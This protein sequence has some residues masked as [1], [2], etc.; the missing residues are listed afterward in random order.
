M[1]E[2]GRLVDLVDVVLRKQY[3]CYILWP[4]LFRRFTAMDLA[5]ILQA[6]AHGFSRANQ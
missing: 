3:P 6:L 2:L 4:P 5:E 1:E